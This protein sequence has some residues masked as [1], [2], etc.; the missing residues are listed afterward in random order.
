[1]PIIRSAKKKVRQD[2]TKTQINKKII[3]SYKK[4]VKTAK[5]SPTKKNIQK[6]YSELDKAVKKNV[7]H[8]NKAARLKSSV[9]RHAKN[10]PAQ[11]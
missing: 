11:K 4:A 10:K 9:T 8:K 5:K 3:E 1:M 2:K 6:A 7:I